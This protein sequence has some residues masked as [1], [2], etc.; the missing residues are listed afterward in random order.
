MA[1]AE[2]NM[3][4]FIVDDS[5]LLRRSLKTMLN[6]LPGAD[7]VGEAADVGRAVSRILEAQP[8]VVILDIRLPDGSGLEVLKTVRS[9]APA[10]RFIVFTGCPA[11]PYKP[12]LLNEG[13]AYF[14][15]KSI[16]EEMLMGCLQSLLE[17]ELSSARRQHPETGPDERKGGKHEQPVRHCN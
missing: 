10:T 4:V 16:E 11:D 13:A 14:F 7:I 12:L 17:G 5:E 6:D 9:R 2:A 8:D 1:S 15:E 3:K